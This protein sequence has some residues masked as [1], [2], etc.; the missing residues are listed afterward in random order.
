MPDE[1][2]QA[3]EDLPESQSARI[4]LGVEYD[5]SAFH[6][7]QVQ[8]H[9]PDTVQQHIETALSTIAAQ[10]VRVICAG[11]TDA[12]VHA[13]GQV[14][15]FDTTSVRDDRAWVL[16]TNTRLPPEIRIRWARRAD[17]GFHA[18]FSATGRRYIYVIDNRPVRP[19]IMGRQ[20]TWQC[21]PLD[22]VKM[23]AAAR[24]LVGEHDFTSYRAVHCQAKN[25]VRTV[26]QLDIERRGELVIMTIHANAFL[27]HMVRNIAGVLMAIGCGK[28]SPEWA[29]QV[30]NVRDRTQGGVTAP[31]AGLYLVDI[32]YPE[33]FTIP[34]CE[35]G[36]PFLLP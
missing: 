33:K 25:P 28:A 29:Q 21:L 18:R 1:V 2:K 20:L 32:D 19:A 34:R 5:G 27:H 36:L 14:I 16:G 35:A 13:T 8:A 30:L 3:S 31:A 6:G 4:A 7:W 9:D 11:R 10:P 12:G 24:Y 22:E 17:P 23:R 15:H 26:D